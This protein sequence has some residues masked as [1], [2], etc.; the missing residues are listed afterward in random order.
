M[1]RF[2]DIKKYTISNRYRIDVS[3]DFLEDHLDRW[4]ERYGIPGDAESVL[5][6]DFQRGHVWAR[7]QQVAYVEYKLAGGPGAD[8]IYFNCPGWM[9]SFEGPFVL[10]DGLQRITACLKFLKGEIPAFGTFIN[11]Y[12]DKNYLSSINF[13]FD[14]NNLKTRTELL[15][16]YLE[17]N[18]QG[19]PHSDKELNRVRE[20]LGEE[21]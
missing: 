7:G 9:N 11:N 1:K 8:K 13:N 19:T 14:V 12:E 16:W 4:I 3:L 20:L 15:Q 21:K 10:V 2:K 18:C 17:I 6:P 5:N